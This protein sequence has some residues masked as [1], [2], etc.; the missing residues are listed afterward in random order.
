MSMNTPWSS[1]LRDTMS[2]PLDMKVQK[3]ELRVIRKKAK[4][5]LRDGIIVTLDRM[6]CIQREI[7]DSKESAVL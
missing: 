5:E 2:L 1:P 7:H 6:R 4:L 3:D